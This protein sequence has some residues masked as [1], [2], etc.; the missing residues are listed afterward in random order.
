MAPKHDR[1]RVCGARDLSGA[2]RELLGIDRPHPYADA[3][4]SRELLGLFPHPAHQPV[5]RARL[6]VELAI[7][8]GGAAG[9]GAE[10]LCARFVYEADSAEE[11]Q[12]PPL[13]SERPS[14]CHEI[15]RRTCFE[16]FFQPAAA[17]PSYWEVNFAPLGDW[18]VYLL[19]RYRSGLREE[20][21]VAEVRRDEYSC[22]S[23]IVVCGFSF[24]L[25]KS[26]GSMWSG[27]VFVGATAVIE[28]AAGTTYWA[29]KHAGG[30][31]DFHLH[32]SFIH[33]LETR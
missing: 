5:P 27:P 16:L 22:G 7:Q 15:W 14:R 19:D 12:I 32:E 6:S 21:G 18:N 3:M 8:S 29:L 11:L 23:G 26:A 30:K 2:V 25:P 28:S 9:G 10:R 17:R 24:A 13:R 33:R 31:P 1:G 4:S 20:L